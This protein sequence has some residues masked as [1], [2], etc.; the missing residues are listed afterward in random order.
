MTRDEIIALDDRGMA[1][2]DAHDTDGFVAL[3]AK[4]VA[5]YGFDELD[6]FNITSPPTFKDKH[7]FGTDLLGRDYLSRVI[8]GLRTSLWVALFVA[9]LVGFA[10]LGVHLLV[11]RDEFSL[12]VRTLLAFPALAAASVD[13]SLVP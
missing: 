6:L 3:F 1:A 12:L 2:W 8:F 10:V 11:I 13:A 7:L 9:L 4:R 5:P